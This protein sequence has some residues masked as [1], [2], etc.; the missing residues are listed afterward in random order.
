MNHKG[1]S[2]DPAAVKQ[3]AFQLE[4][5]EDALWDMVGRPIPVA[6]DLNDGGDSE[7]GEFLGDYHRRQ[8]SAAQR[9]AAQRSTAPYRLSV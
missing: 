4:L 5:E 2:H 6:L 3:L 8:R 7:S 1:L 9:S